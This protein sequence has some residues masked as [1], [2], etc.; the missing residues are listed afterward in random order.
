MIIYN[1]YYD[2]AYNNYYLK[3]ISIEMTNNK[4]GLRINY[5]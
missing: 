5:Q 4:C 1:V 2:Y 3:Q